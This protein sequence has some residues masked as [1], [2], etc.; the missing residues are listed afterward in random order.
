MGVD[1]VVETLSVVLAIAPPIGVTVGGENKQEAPEG[2]PL[3]LKLTGALKPIC[4]VT[5]TVME[6]DCPALSDRLGTDATI[7]KSPVTGPDDAT[8]IAPNKP[9]FSSLMPALK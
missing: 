4:G 3:Q 6:A 2:I 7:E 8:E 1:V 9:L 5:L